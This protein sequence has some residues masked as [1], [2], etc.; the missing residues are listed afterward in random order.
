MTLISNLLNQYV[1]Q[2]SDSNKSIRT[3]LLD[4][5]KQ[6]NI[7]YSTLD[8]LFY[9]A[10]V[11]SLKTAEKLSLYFQE[12]VYRLMEINSDSTKYIS[13]SENRYV[14]QIIRKGKRHTK[15]FNTLQE[16]Q[17]HR[18]VILSDF[19]NR[20]V[21]PKTYQ[22]KLKSLIN[23]KFG[24]LTVLSITDPQKSDKD[25]RR[26]AVCQCDCGTIKTIGLSELQKVPHRGATLSCGCLQ[27]EVAKQNFL[28]GYSEESIVKRIKAQ[29]Q[30]VEPNINN[31]STRIR[32]I[33]YDRSKKLYRVTIVRNGVRYGG[34]N[35]KKLSDAKK[36]K[37]RLLEE[38]KNRK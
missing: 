30:K 35:F 3:L 18:Q 13:Q 1:N 20:N 8:K 22:E 28:K 27:K 29:H 38:I 15:S 11:P 12:P 7:P 26:R 19:D 36:Y 24:R 17:H 2:N 31:R 21:F 16:A 37:T 32:H 4:L 33:F 5:S 9:N 10:Q 25:H 23:K 14:V 6:L 34:K